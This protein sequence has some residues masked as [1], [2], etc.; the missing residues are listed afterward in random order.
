MK[1]ANI[2]AMAI[3]NIAG[4]CLIKID[5]DAGLTGASC[6]NQAATLESRQQAEGSRDSTY[7][8]QK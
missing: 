2:Q 1:I 8:W 7:V 5:I 3:Q 4:N 6:Q